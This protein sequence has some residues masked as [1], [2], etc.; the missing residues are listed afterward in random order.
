MSNL[1]TTITVKA[2]SSGVAAGLEPGKRSIKELGGVASAT[3]KEVG[4]IGDG[5]DAAASKIERDT[6]RISNEFK[7]LQVAAETAGK[8]LSESMVIKANAYGV[9]LASIQAQIDGAKAFERAQLAS[10]QAL[11]GGAGSLKSVA[12][13]AGATSAA[14]RNV[15]AQFTDIVTSLQG[16]QKPL[17]VLLQQGGQLKDMFGG[18]GNAAKALGGYVLGLVNPYTVAAAAAGGLAIAY[19]SGAAESRALSNA[20]IL[21]GNSAGASASGMMAMAASIDK[22]TGTQGGAVEA[23]AQISQFGKVSSENLEKFTTTAI[24]FEKVSG[25]AVSETAKKFAELKDA[26]LEATLKLNESMGYL[27][28]T[29]YNQ[30]KALTETGRAT[31]AAALAQKAFD[32]STASMATQMEKNLGTVERSWNKVKGAVSETWDA[33][34][35]IG[36][37]AGLEGQVAAA[38]KMVDVRRQAAESIY[39]T[40]GDKEKLSAAQN[41]LLGYQELLKNQQLS[42]KY[43]GERVQATKD[44][45]AWQKEGEKHASKQEKM[46]RE[47]TAAAI[48]GQREILRGTI[49]QQDLEQRFANIREANKESAA[50]KVSTAGES[51]IAGIRARVIETQKYI[52]ALKIGGIE[53]AK[54]NEGEKLAVKIK[55]DLLTSISGVARAN[56]IASLA[57]AEKLA[58]L[59]KVSAAEEGHQKAIKKSVDEYQNLIDATYKGADSITEQ[60]ARQEAANAVFGKGKAAIEAMTLAELNHQMAEAQ[61][62]DRFS[63]QYIAGLQAKIDAQTRY[64]KSLDAADYKTV[65]AHTQELLRSAKEMDSLYRSEAE[66]AYTTGVERE[67]IIAMREVEIKFAKELAKIE[68]SNMSDAE[69]AA[70][71]QVVNQAKQIEG[72][73][74]LAKVMQSDWSKTVEKYD[75]IFRSGFA[76]M[77]NNGKGAWES[78]SKSLVTTFKTSVADQLYKMFAQPFVMQL[79]ASV[80]GIT[81]SAVASAAQSGSMSGLMGDAGAASS[82]FSEGGSLAGIGAMAGEFGAGLA[83]GFASTMAGASVSGTVGVAAEVGGAAGAGLGIGAAMPYIAAAAVAYSLL[84]Q[85]HGTPTATTGDANVSFSGAGD[86]TGRK[87]AG[88]YFWGG[89]MTK[90]ADDFVVGLNKTYLDTAK[91][92]GIAAVDTYF[93]YSGNTGKDGAAPNFAI[94]SS[95]GNQTYSSGE[96]ALS[97]A[98][99]GLAASRAVFNALQKSDLP[100]YLA[101]A[102]D[103]MTASS[104]TQEQ[105]AASMAGATALKQ[106]HDQ[107]QAL[108]FAALKDL[109]FQAT[110][111]LAGFAGGLDKLGANLGTYYD[112]FYTSEEKT[113]QL[114]KN[115][116]AAFESLGLVMP[117]LD[118]STR[119]SY[120]ALVDELAAKDLSVAANARAYSGALALASAVDQ[121]APALLDTA[122]ATADAAKIASDAAAAASKAAAD[123]LGTL[124]QG[125]SDSARSSVAESLSAITDS[126]AAQKTVITDAYS[127]QAD[128]INASLST[129]GTSISKLQSL[130]SSLKSTLDGMRISGSDSAYRAD[131]QAQ[132]RAALATARSGGGLPVDG[133]LTSA[134]GTISKPSDQ[135]YGNF[136]DYARDFYST[137]NDIAALGDLT[138]QQLTADEV[139]QKLLTTQNATLK[140]GFDAEVKRLDALVSEAKVQADAVMKSAGAT[141]S[142]ADALARFTSTL[143]ATLTN[144]MATA[145]DKYD[146]NNSSG[147]DWVEF[148]QS[149]GG[150][151]SEATLNT[152]FKAADYNGDGHI[153]QL[154]AIKANTANL[155]AVMSVSGAGGAL[156]GAKTFTGTEVAGAIKALADSGATTAQIINAANANFGVTSASLAQVATVTGNTGI[157]DYQ[158]RVD[159][160]TPIPASEMESLM[161]AVNADAAARGVSAEES[162]YI[163]AKA[164]GYNAGMVDKKMGWGNGAANAWAT[165]HGYPAFAAGINYVPH[166]MTALIHEG[167]AVVPKVYNPFNPNAAQ[168]GGASNEELVSELRAL[169]AELAEIKANTRATAGHTAG[170]DRKLARVIPGNAVIIQA[171]T[172]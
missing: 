75:D 55:E 136:V 19:E 31:E 42:A 14:L 172:A 5:S 169:R 66:Y 82:L 104:M 11:L 18:A 34:K 120:R 109:S 57:E 142:M 7:R 90:A 51:E 33:I 115:T 35:G 2:D 94:R 130:S 129:V 133:A 32:A 138:G 149:F 37:D 147:I 13:S 73:A 58:A 61:G 163:W 24:R 110:Q 78:F 128:K 165:S 151:A 12:M 98:A 105:I 87:T 9:P 153:S 150:L 126:V 111:N 137:A 102:F 116:S 46:T 52:D 17:T 99:V 25:T 158:K 54:L 4:K 20:L 152:L 166:D 122:K 112:K 44:Y 131:A 170:T 49:T 123:A 26:P 48:A 76:D 6:R 164:N 118:A 95:A 121:L 56:K 50:P 160:T 27:T 45:V 39:A 10:N 85:D 146:A 71:R 53:G 134:L 154:E 89:S 132:I 36:R 80:I 135:L 167:E 107:L 41:Q 127:F 15:P 29:L 108:P 84:T 140:S 3:G 67:K 72:S 79:V 119:A 155:L 100:K 106:F 101:G 81:G 162:L 59:L 65:N 124:L 97:D 171:A 70:Q 117:A 93:S 103:G 91:N 69:K 43:E 28:V 157:T 161:Q 96:T 144:S 141:L 83:N 74:T 86:V 16:G 139:T 92:L 114:T 62:S 40:A 143:G 8:S 60:A 63:D 68:A 159:A 77:L 21:S 168:S 30:L 47:L 1:D 23:L 88:D 64:A 113:A 38:Q 148:K 145:F 125:W 156:S 22:I